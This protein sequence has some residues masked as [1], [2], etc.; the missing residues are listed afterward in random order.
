LS[1]V[2][3]LLGSW[4][5]VFV[6]V[7]VSGVSWHRERK[8]PPKNKNRGSGFVFAFYKA[9]CVRAYTRTCCLLLAASPFLLP[10]RLW[11]LGLLLLLLLLVVVV[12]VAAATG[13]LR[14]DVLSICI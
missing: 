3:V 12:V 6:F 5:F 13:L 14:L 8:T 9:M 7:G 11:P 2:F 1:L 4:V 10:K